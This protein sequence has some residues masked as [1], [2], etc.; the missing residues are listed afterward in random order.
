MFNVYLSILHLHTLMGNKTAKIVRNSKSLQS[1]VNSEKD[2][3]Y[4]EELK[5][6]SNNIIDEP[7]ESIM[8]KVQENKIKRYTLKQIISSISE[9]NEC[10]DIPKDIQAIFKRNYSLI[11]NRM[12]KD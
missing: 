3:K 9:N 5:L 7:E 10:V 12:S 1:I 8:S 4:L 6:L 11:S 2:N